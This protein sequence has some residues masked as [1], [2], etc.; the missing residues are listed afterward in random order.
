MVSDHRNAI[1]AA[2][3]ASPMVLFILGSLFKRK[4][5]TLTLRLNEGL[6]TELQQ[7]SAQSGF[8]VT[9][10]II[11]AIWNSILSPKDRQR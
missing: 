9:A 6:F 5:K 3:T 1:V 4:E 10:L 7:I 11:A 8:T 2:V